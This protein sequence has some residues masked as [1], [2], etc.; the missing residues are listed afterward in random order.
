MVGTTIATMMA[1]A[2]S[3]I[4]RAAAATGPRAS[5][6][7]PEQ[8]ARRIV[9]KAAQRAASCAM[10][11]GPWRKLYALAPRAAARE[12]IHVCR[13]GEY[14]ERDD[15]RVH[16]FNDRPAFRQRERRDEHRE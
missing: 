5:S 16:D 8:L 2:F 9:R 12:E 1:S 15:E 6:T 13:A 3:I 4:C 7:P 10:G 14:A 11:R